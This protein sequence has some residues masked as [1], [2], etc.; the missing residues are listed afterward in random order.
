VVIDLDKAVPRSA[1]LISNVDF[2][3]T[4]ASFPPEFTGIADPIESL[5]ALR[6]HCDGFLAVTLGAQGAMAVI[7]DECE[8]FPAFKVQAVDTTGAG[9]IFHGAFIYGLLRNWT[10]EGIM[11]F[12]N[13]AAA[14]NCTHLG[15]RGGI[16][17]LS[18]ILALADSGTRHSL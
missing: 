4:S 6:K 12:A 18:E 10:V 17:S 5:L 11:T 14:L 7:N 1:E 8:R 15:A 2:L 13:A 16:P 3:I 9:D